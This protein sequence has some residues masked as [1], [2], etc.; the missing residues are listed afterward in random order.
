MPIDQDSHMTESNQA[1]IAELKEL[2][3]RRD[4]AMFVT[5][6]STGQMRSRPMTTQ[7]VDDQ[8]ELWFMTRDDTSVAQDVVSTPQVCLNFAADDDNRYVVLYG[9][10]KTVRDAKRIDEIWTVAHNAF[11]PDGKDDPKLV[12][13]KVVPS[14]AEVWSGPSSSVGKLIAF[15]KALVTSDPEALGEKHELKR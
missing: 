15:A 9:D 11:F 12:L 8:G 1:P 13:L 6:D 5:S 4:I 2:L 14:R 10:C 7:R 3:E